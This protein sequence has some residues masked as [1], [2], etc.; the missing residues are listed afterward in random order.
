MNNR[1]KEALIALL[2]EEVIVTSWG[3]YDL[4]ITEKSFT[5]KVDGFK[6]HGLISVS[7]LSSKY[8]INFDTGE[9]ILCNLDKLVETLD[10]KIEKTEVYDI[11]IEKWLL[12]L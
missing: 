5:F 4:N 1:I 12:D 11:S 2:D 3:L 10:S 7:L 6:F 9:S 8:L